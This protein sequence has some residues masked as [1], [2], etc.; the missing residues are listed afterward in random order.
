MKVAVAELHRDYADK[1]AFGEPIWD[2]AANNWQMSDENRE[3]VDKMAGILVSSTDAGDRAGSY[4]QPIIA[5]NMAQQGITPEES[6][7]R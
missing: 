3:M 1:D 4:L 6:S 5:F 2:R 7:Q